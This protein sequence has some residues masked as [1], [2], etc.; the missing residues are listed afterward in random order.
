MKASNNVIYRCIADEH[1]LVP[2]GNAALNNNGLIV[3]N[4]IGAE[5]WAMLGEE[6]TQEKIVEHI[7]ERYD[8]DR[9]TAEA[10]TAEF[11]NT[12]CGRGLL[13]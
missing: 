2:V 9:A 6:T 1:V 4:E 12:L 8:V 5:I 13:E 10:D 11:L 7:M 3:L